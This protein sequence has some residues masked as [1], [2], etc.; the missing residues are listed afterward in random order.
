VCRGGGDPSSGDPMKSARRFTVFCRVALALGGSASAAAGAGEQRA[1]AWLGLGLAQEV[2]LISG[3][4]VCTEQSQLHEGFS[5]F[6][7]WGSQYHGTPLEGRAGAVET[8]VVMA[9]TRIFLAGDVP[10]SSDLTLGL[11]AGY[12]VA[13]RGPTADGGKPFFPVH[14]EL[15]GQYWLS[16]QAYPETFSGFLLA[17]GGIAQIDARAVANVAEDRSVPPPPGQLDNPDQ[18]T[19]TVYEKMGLSFV[20]IGAGVYVP[21]AAR[22]GLSGDLK[23]VALF[24][25]YGTALQFE[26]GYAVGF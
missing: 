11:R 24:P 17:S 2:A 1:S 26:L 16:D 25:D 18:Q 13:G 6:R 15:R 10:L 20:A 7:Q 12:A 5:C 22:H 9:T 21:L 23:A 3:R 8:Q 19:L 14:A 4:E